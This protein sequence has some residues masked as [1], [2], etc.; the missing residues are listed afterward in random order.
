[1]FL[2][3]SK[4]D[5]NFFYLINVAQTLLKICLIWTIIDQNEYVVLNTYNTHTHTIK[6]TIFAYMYVN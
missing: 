2:E 6:L 3:F 4:Y 5:F 1:M